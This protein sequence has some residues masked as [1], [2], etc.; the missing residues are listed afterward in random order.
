M[1]AASPVAAS[2][3]GAYALAGRYV[4]DQVDAAVSMGLSVK[5]LVGD[6][7]KNISLQPLALDASTVLGISVGPGFFSIEPAE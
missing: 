4:G 6:S 2:A 7:D 3:R 5:V 1:L